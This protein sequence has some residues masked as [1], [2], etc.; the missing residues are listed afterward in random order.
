[1]AK[2]IEKAE[3]VRA[4]SAVQ[5]SRW[6]DAFDQWL[7]E[8]PAVR[9][10]PELR[11]LGQGLDLLRVEEFTEGDEL[12]VRAEMPGLDPDEDV[13]ITVTDH[14]LQL[15][16]ERRQESKTEEKGAYRSEF[17]YGSFARAIPLPPGATD[18]DVKATYKDGILEVRIPVDR[19]QAEA[20]KV[21][22]QRA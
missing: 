7:A 8:W 11:E 15:R 14:T 21:P 20:T 10:W 5:P 6:S 2:T 12:V 16:A 3:P 1:M 9:V 19:A 17:R 18:K 22:I 4:T 13:H